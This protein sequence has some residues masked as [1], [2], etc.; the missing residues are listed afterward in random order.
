VLVLSASPRVWGEDL[1]AEQVSREIQEKEKMRELFRS[2][3]PRPLPRLPRGI[4]RHVMFLFVDHWEPG[5]GSVA[6]TKANLWYEDYGRMARRHV[7]A[8]GCHPKHDWFCL[9]LEKK[10]LQIIAKTVFDGLGEMNIH[11]HH[12][13]VNDDNNDNCSEMSGLIDQ[14]LMYLN[15][16][17]ACLTAEEHP[18]QTF[19]FIHGMW[20]LDNSRFVN[21]HRQYCGCN[22]ELNLLMSKNCY[23]DFTFPAWGPMQPTVIQ[24][25][26]FATRD[27]F[28]PTSYNIPLNVREITVNFPPA[29]DEF[30]IFQGPNC[31]TNI[32]QDDAPTLSRMNTWVNYNVSISG[33]S[34]WVF[35]KMYSHGSQ[36][37]SYPAGYS[38]LIGSTM[39]KFY[40]DIERDYNDG[41]NYKLHYC[42]AREGYNIAMAAADGVDD[43]D[44]NHF[45]D[46]KIPPPV[47]AFYYC[48][49]FYNLLSRDLVHGTT[50]IQILETPLPSSLTIWTK[51]FGENVLVSEKNSGEEHYQPGDA[52]ISSSCSI[53]LILTDDT[54]SRYYLLEQVSTAVKSE[55]WERYR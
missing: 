42:T 31:D 45:R 43:N 51:D 15:K 47:N 3:P 12:G 19:G 26:I 21:G 5:Y 39:D 14:Y 50:V 53:P 6:L 32:D 46:Y 9:Y 54:P 1:L 28:Q 2:V 30:V 4:L 27:S 52:H 23:A 55:Y 18:Q 35:V 44:P 22:E 25:R 48:D 24:S 11:I 16:V 10:P 20:A 41:V 8:D 40:S 29:R 7:D 33:K 49:A 38:N 13:T 36:T 34:A 17:G 37:L